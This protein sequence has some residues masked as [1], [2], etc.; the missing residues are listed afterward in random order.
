[1]QKAISPAPPP[2]YNRGK[3]RHS[4]P[5]RKLSTMKQPKIFAHRGAS[6][7][8]PENTLPAFALA[9][10]QGADGIELDVHLTR[11][12]QLVVIHDETLERTTNGSG[13]VKDHTLAQLQQ[14]RADNHMPGFADASIP[15]LE[16]VLELVKPTG[17]LVNIELKTSLIWYEGLEEKTV[18]LVRAMGM[19]GRVIYSSFNHY[20]I[21]KVQQLDPEAETAYLYSDIICDVEKYAAARGVKGLHPGLWN[22]QM[23]D[24]LRIYLDSGLAVRVWTVNERQ[25]MEQLLTAGADVITND[26]VLALQVR[27]ELGL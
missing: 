4:R 20:S 22:V 25:D 24:F 16:Q 26:P 5:E 13:W 17:M 21:E 1:M 6:S 27:K 2:C 9:A 3:Y 23:G 10:S 7:Y 19:E 11:D 8:A 18:E 15:T 14:L 12:G